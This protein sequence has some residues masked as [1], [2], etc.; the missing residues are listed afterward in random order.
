LQNAVILEFGGAT[1]EEIVIIIGDSLF[2]PVKITSQTQHALPSGTSFSREAWL[3]IQVLNKET[4]ELLFSSGLIADSSDLNINDENL[5]LFTS[6][7]LDENG[8][9]T[10]SVSQTHDIIKQ[11]LPASPPRYHTYKFV[12][13]FNL[14]NEFEISIRMRFRAFKPHLLRE[15]HPELLTN[16][17]VFEMAR[18]DTTYII[19]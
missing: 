16:L 3:E 6:Y 19:P 18:I 4:G 13:D 14:V 8:D 12:G 10:N 15:D 1:K 11:M 9:T 2:I 5:L 17:P 7:L